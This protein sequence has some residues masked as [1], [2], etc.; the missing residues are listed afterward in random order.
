MS[1]LLVKHP[2]R[3]IAKGGGPTGY[4][5]NLRTAAAEFGLDTGVTFDIN[6][7]MK[8]PPR[9]PVPPPAPWPLWKKVYN[10]LRRGYGA[11]A[12]TVGSSIPKPPDYIPENFDAELD[13]FE[14]WKNHHYGWIT[15]S[16]ARKMF[17]ADLLFA[18]DIWLAS[19]IARLC[20]ELSKEKL[21]LISHSPTWTIIEATARILPDYPDPRYLNIKRVRSIVDENLETMASIRAVLWPCAEAVPEYP[22]WVEVNAN[23]R[24]ANV[25]AETGVQ[26]PTGTLSG[27]DMRTQWQIE[28]NQR[29]VLFIGRAHPHKGFHRFHSWA[30]A[31]RKQGDTGYVFVHAGQPPNDVDKNSPLRHVGYIKDNAAA[32]AAADLVVIPNQFSYM[33][34]GLLE[35][36]SLGAKIAIS[37]TGGHRLFPEICPD[38]PTIPDTNADDEWQTLKQYI[39]E[40]AA[41]TTR[42]EAFQ[43][44]WESRFSLEPFC[45][46]HVRV[47][48]ELTK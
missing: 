5:Y 8:A 17:D 40:Y 21:V 38:I 19:A 32:Y 45:A 31:A 27:A 26:K 42:Q 25:F 11:A 13:A 41:T 35:S 22:E 2:F 7:D 36:L 43:K 48:R 37:P 23:G 39:Q 16:Y 9:P 4:L 18:N 15:E 44:L 46:N 29:V 28:P 20:P 24:G 10:L 47:C 34:I 33:D 6:E 30:Q 3:D 14:D 12:T 1:D